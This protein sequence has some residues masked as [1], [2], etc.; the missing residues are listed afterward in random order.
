MGVTAD[1]VYDL[2]ATNVCD[3][4]EA[5][6]L[7]WKA[8]MEDFPGIPSKPNRAIRVLKNVLFVV[9]LSLDLK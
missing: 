6:G 3:L 8:Y 1:T 4:L 5:K 2:D 9:G 7:T